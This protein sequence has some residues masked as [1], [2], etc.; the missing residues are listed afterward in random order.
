MTDAELVALLRNQLEYY[1]SGGR[2]VA[3][4]RIEQLLTERKALA[5]RDAGYDVF[6]NLTNAVEQLRFCLQELVEAQ[7]KE[8]TIMNDLISFIKGSSKSWMELLRTDSNI[9]G[10]IFFR[11][12]CAASLNILLEKFAKNFMQSQ[13][14]SQ[15]RES[16][17]TCFSFPYIID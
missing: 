12:G 8:I 10:S 14:K 15:I 2:F 17:Q 9:L 11:C 5:M 13:F 6:A 3:A 1:N 4:N 7:S 16:I